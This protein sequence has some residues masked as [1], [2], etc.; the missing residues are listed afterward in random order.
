MEVVQRKSWFKRNW[1]WFVPVGCGTIILV[2]VLAIGGLFF[3]GTELLSGSAPAEYALE[4]A[5]Q[6][7]AVIQA[8]GEPI[9]QKGM[10]T[11][12]FNFKNSDGDADLTI[13]IEGPHGKGKLYVVG[14]KRDGEWSYSYLYVWI[15]GQS[16]TIDLLDE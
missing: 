6:N 16:E 2:F 3:L 7:E 9:E 10:V 1:K 5:S 11:G 12:E 8:L 13:P 15:Q 4:K 14:S